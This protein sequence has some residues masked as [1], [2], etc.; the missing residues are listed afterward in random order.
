MLPCYASSHENAYNRGID[1]TSCIHSVEAVEQH[2][3]LGILETKSNTQQGIKDMLGED[4]FRRLIQIVKDTPVEPL[5]SND[6]TPW[7]RDIL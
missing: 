6:P 3:L 4:D 2:L 1:T 5:N 7:I